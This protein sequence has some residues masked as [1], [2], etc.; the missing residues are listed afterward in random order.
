MP[1]VRLSLFVR[2]LVMWVSPFMTVSYVSSVEAQSQRMAAPAVRLAELRVDPAQLD[3]FI[4]AAKEHVD[5]AMRL[6]PG[7]LAFHVAAEK[8]HKDRVRVL[9]MYVDE[10]AYEAHLQSPHFRR[11]RAATQ[12]M[13]LSRELHEA[14]PV[15]LGAKPRLPE[16]RPMVR[17]AEIDI[18][19]LQLDAYK[20]AVSKEIESSIRVEPGVLAIYA[21]CLRDRPTHLRFFEIYA[22]DPA[23]RQHIASPH[24]RRYVDT[25]KPMIT[26]RVLLEA[27]PIVL[28]LKTRR[29]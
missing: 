19:P 11:F 20:A 22:D 12:G 28:R 25:T 14:V 8:D 4:A 21:V 2:R 27:E 17:V 5:A 7:I 15:L 13:T 23:Y 6:E 9:E 1:T 10:R 3:A 26:S 29:N 16:A 18:D 24:F